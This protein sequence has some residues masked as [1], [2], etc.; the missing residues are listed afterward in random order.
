VYKFILLLAMASVVVVSAGAASAQSTGPRTGASSVDRHPQTRPPKL[1]EEVMSGLSTAERAQELRKANLNT[2][3]AF[4]AYQSVVAEARRDRDPTDAA[5][6]AVLAVE[7]QSATREQ[8]GRFGEDTDERARELQ[9]VGRATRRAFD[10]FQAAYWREQDLAEAAGAEA[11]IAAYG[12]DTPAAAP[13]AGDAASDPSAPANA[14]T[15]E[16]QE[17][18]DQDD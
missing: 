16:A 12:A 18:G 10:K 8:I 9:D 1:P 13:V 3:K 11:R 7:A 17:S 6:A 2:R 5:A 4:G 15:Q 14:M